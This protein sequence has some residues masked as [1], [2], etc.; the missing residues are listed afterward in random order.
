VSLT[1]TEIRPAGDADKN[2]QLVD[3]SADGRVMIALYPTNDYASTIFYISVDYGVTWNVRDVSDENPYGILMRQIRLSGD[4]NTLYALLNSDNYWWKLHK[5]TDNG[6][7]W[8]LLENAPFYE[9]YYTLL[10]NY[11]GQ[12]VWLSGLNGS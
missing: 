9:V 10:V 2:W 5:S 12:K 8:T 3:M 4:G 6:V 1:F 11:N 7:T